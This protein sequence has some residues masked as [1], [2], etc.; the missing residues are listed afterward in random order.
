MICIY[1]TYVFLNNNLGRQVTTQEILP[2]SS[3]EFS[4]LIP[5]YDLLIYC[6]LNDIFHRESTI[7]RDSASSSSIGKAVLRNFLCTYM[8]FK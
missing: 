3:Q 4:S 5:R 7:I 6:Y 1:V 8:M 2:S